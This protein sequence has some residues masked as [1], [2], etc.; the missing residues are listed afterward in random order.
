MRIVVSGRWSVVSKSTD[1]IHNPP[2][3]L[4]FLLERVGEAMKQATN[5]IGQSYHFGC[6]LVGKEL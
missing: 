4:N 6:L 2:L 3:A 5:I 1:Q